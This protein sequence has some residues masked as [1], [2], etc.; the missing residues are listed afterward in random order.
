VGR[1]VSRNSRPFSESSGSFTTNSVPSE[2]AWPRA[3]WPRATWH[4]AQVR[5]SYTRSLFF[6]QYSTRGEKSLPSS[7]ISRTQSTHIRLVERAFDSQ[8]SL[9]QFA[10]AFSFFFLFLSLPPPRPPPPPQHFFFYSFSPPPSRHLFVLVL[11]FI[12]I[13]C[14][15]RLTFKRF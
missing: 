11:C 13:Q 10:F 9:Y 1:R 8:I 14:P 5:P 2:S 12:L 7:R 4:R 6:A 3:T 15:E